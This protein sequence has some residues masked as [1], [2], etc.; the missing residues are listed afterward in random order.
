MQSEAAVNSR[1]LNFAD[2]SDE[3]GRNRI[4]LGG[5]K[6]PEHEQGV[7]QFSPIEFSRRS[8]VAS[9]VV[10]CVACCVAPCCIVSYPPVVVRAFVVATI[11]RTISSSPSFRTR[12]AIRWKWS[13]TNSSDLRGRGRPLQINLCYLIS[14]KIIRMSSSL[15]FVSFHSFH[16][17]TLAPSQHSLVR[18]LSIFNNAQITYLSTFPCQSKEI[19]S[20]CICDSPIFIRVLRFDL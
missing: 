11:H 4:R 8:A 2:V 1:S 10:L 17:P 16:L 9:G 18:E 20:I 13:R 3:I 5:R 6:R 19:I 14:I 15:D 7:S 12:F